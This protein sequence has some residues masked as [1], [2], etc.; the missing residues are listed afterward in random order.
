[1]KIILLGAPGSGKG[2]QAE[3]I[4]GLLDIAH[5]ST[6]DIFRNHIEKMTPLGKQVKEYIEKGLL[7]P[8]Q[9]TVEIVRERLNLKDCEKGFVLDGF[10]RTLPQAKALEE[11]LKEKGMKLD[12]VINL[13]VDDEG[14]IAR[15]SGRRMCTCGATYHLLRKPSKQEGICDKC[16]KELYVREDDKPETVRK[17]LEN[18]HSNTKPLMDFYDRKGLVRNVDGSP[19]PDK[20]SELVR[21]V[22][23]KN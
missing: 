3:F 7:V 16:G 17:R 2:T 6:G 15:M 9:L 5:I 8:D 12:M 11:I 10:P 4:T 13:V 22:I 1:M 20:V 23:R 18:Y 14:V 21:E 19:L